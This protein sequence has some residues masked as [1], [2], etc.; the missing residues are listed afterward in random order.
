MVLDFSSQD[1]CFAWD[2]GGRQ[3]PPCHVRNKPDGS[4]RPQNLVLASYTGR[5]DGC[6]GL[7]SSPGH[8]RLDASSL[9]NNVDGGRTAS[10]FK[11]Y[12][13]KKSWQMFQL[14]HKQYA[15]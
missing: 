12:R 9:S 10:I 7:R 11:N 13:E 4:M 5:T 3:L 6:G 1:S 14:A 15:C 8:V 2:A